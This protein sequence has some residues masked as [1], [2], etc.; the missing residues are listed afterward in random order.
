[1]K[2]VMTLVMLLVVL[3]I[4]LTSQ[5]VFSDQEYDGA[6]YHVTVTNYDD[7]VVLKGNHWNGK[8]KVFTRGEKF[9]ITGEIAGYSKI[10]KLSYNVWNERYHKEYTRMATTPDGNTFW[11]F[12]LSKLE[13]DTRTSEFADEDE[14]TIRCYAKKEGS[15]VATLLFEMYIELVDRNEVEILEYSPRKDLTVEKGEN[16]PLFFKAKGLPMIDEMRVEINGQVAKRETSLER[17]KEIFYTFKASEYDPGT[18]RIEF[19]AESGNKEDSELVEIKIREDNEVKILNY[20]PSTD[21]L[22]ESDEIISLSFEA[23]GTP[24]LDEMCF[25]INGIPV[26]REDRLSQ[27]DE[28]VFKFDAS[29]F[30][31]GKHFIEFVAES[32]NEEV[33]ES[34]TIEIKEDNVVNILNYSPSRDKAIQVDETLK[35]SFDAK[36]SPQI[37][38]M[39]ISIDG[40][41][42]ESDSRL[43]REGELA[44]TLRA[45]DYE[46]GLHLVEFIARSGD[47]K[48]RELIEITIEENKVERLNVE[49]SDNKLNI[50]D[51]GQLKATAI[52]SNGKKEIVT[53]DCEFESMKSEVLKID[54]RGEYT[55]LKGLGDSVELKTSYGGIIVS[56]KVFI[57]EEPAIIKNLELETDKDKYKSTDEGVLTVFAID[58]DGNRENITSKADFISNDTET[59]RIVGN[60]FYITSSDKESVKIIAAYGGKTVSKVIEIKSERK[61]LKIE[62][63]GFDQ[64]LRLNDTAS[65]KI[66]ASYSDYTSENVTNQAQMYTSL[67]GKLK[68]DN[69]IFT[70]LNT[71]SEKVVLTAKYQGKSAEK[72]LTF[73]GK[74]FSRLSVEFTNKIYKVGDEGGFKV[75]AVYDDDSE[76]DITTDCDFDTDDKELIKV[77]KSGE[78]IVNANTKDSADVQISLY[79]AGQIRTITQKIRLEEKSYKSIEVELIGITDRAEVGETISYQ[80]YGTTSDGKK[81]D[82]T[83]DCTVDLS[84]V[85]L[86]KVGDGKIEVVDTYNYNGVQNVKMT[87]SLDKLT[88]QKDI[89]II[90][91]KRFVQLIIESDSENNMY[92]KRQ[93]GAL[94]VLA[95]FGDGTR[96]DVTEFC[97]FEVISGNGLELTG[98]TFSINSNSASNEIVIR[99][100]Y[101]GRLINSFADVKINIINGSGETAGDILY[102][103]GLIEGLSKTEKVLNGEGKMTRAMIV[104]LLAELMNKKAEAENFNLPSGFTDVPAG[105]WY[106]KY[107]GYA[108]VAGWTSGVGNGK[109]DPNGKV[110]YKQACN[111]MLKALGYNDQWHNAEEFAEQMKIVT[112]VSE[113]D[114]LNRKEGFELMLD[115]LKTPK[116]GGKYPLGYEELDIEEF[117]GE[118]LLGNAQ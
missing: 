48:D 116:R 103:L 59:L 55:A 23:E 64:V 14:L 80:V 71:T 6:G 5:I 13:I 42:V 100:S 12:D 96:K 67:L 109:F 3:G 78:F 49:I 107:V 17:N 118:F 98:Q 1:M 117:K 68:F 45:S 37:D 69:G 44:Y 52:Y 62:I 36:G 88:E 82:V 50:G 85:M 60:Q 10:K 93:S 58:D 51:S 7:Y 111:F 15:D 84:S 32:G 83:S 108:S 65:Y 61:L 87:F 57:E 34:I 63:E 25:Y 31:I 4:V 18:Y 99:S 41:T 53:E 29:G 95:V 40:K 27:K 102:R 112:L 46:A 75:L 104:K 113:M 89:M 97:D 11:S 76:V 92:S 8:R 94:K 30:A 56:S 47:E 22:I 21:K 90:S 105:Q 26:R 77:F 54:N 110:T 19:I 114:S 2:R 43:G 9:K 73:K 35:L 81:E 20:T 70:V 72:E 106:S 91:N 74:E 66:I 101:P 33:S 115:T 24:T 39:S 38:A 79:V 28:L 86:R 16:V